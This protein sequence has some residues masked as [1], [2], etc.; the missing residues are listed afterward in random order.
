[1]NPT[2]DPFRSTGPPPPSYQRSSVAPETHVDASSAAIHEYITHKSKRWSLWQRWANIVILVCIACFATVFVYITL[3]CI[4]PSWQL[5]EESSRTDELLVMDSVGLT[6]PLVQSRN[7]VIRRHLWKLSDQINGTLFFPNTVGYRNAA[8]AWVQQNSLEPLWYSH[9]DDT[10]GIVVIQVLNEADVQ[11]VLPVLSYLYTFYQFPFRVRSGGHH[12]IGYSSFSDVRTAVTDGAI[13]SLSAMNQIS[14]PPELYDLSNERTNSSIIIIEPA[15]TVRNVLQQITKPL[16]YGGVIGFCSSVAEAGFVLGGGYGLQ[17]RMYGLGLDNV[18]S[19][20]VVLADGRRINSSA[21]EHVDLFW[22]LRG[23]GS[24]SFGVVTAM[25][26]QVHPVSDTIHYLQLRLTNH[27]DIA[28]FLHHLGMMNSQLPDNVLVMHDEP[29]VINLSW[30]GRDATDIFHGDVFLYDL[31]R[32]LIGPSPASFYIQQESISW[33]DTFGPNTTTDSN[34]NWG[35]SV[36]AAA[37]W[38]GFLLPENNT[39]EIWSDLMGHMAA[40]ILDSEPYLLPDIE[41]WGGAIRRVHETATAFPYRSAVYNVGVLLI[42]PV[43]ETNAHVVFEQE[44]R[45]VNRWWYKIGQY[46]TG[47]YVNYPMASLLDNED[48][49]HY[50]KMFWGENLQRLVQIKQKYDP[51]NVFHFPMSVPL[52]L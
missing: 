29:D 49:N 28:H 51:G 17:S 5:T 19:F 15:V 41:L 9:E 46:L 11:L 16:G 45:K 38:T 12:K 7:Q 14:A 4:D 22:A 31:V 40:G 3:K 30:S 10:I 27:G 24:G 13:L 6:L 52:N 32:S 33:S 37:C 42:I 8:T 1:M 2:C 34:K 44:K 18:L 25:E 48:S 20:R 39:A 21:T 43:N 26:Y 35:D 47:S 23:A 50:A 36:F